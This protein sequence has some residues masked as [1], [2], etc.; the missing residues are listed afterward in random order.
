MDLERRAQSSSEFPLN[1]YRFLAVN[2]CK[3]Y[4]PGFARLHDLSRSCVRWEETSIRHHSR[5]RRSPRVQWSNPWQEKIDNLLSFIYDTGCVFSSVSPHN[6][7]FKAASLIVLLPC[8]GFV[9]GKWDHFILPANPNPESWRRV[10]ASYRLASVHWCYNLKMEIIDYDQK[11]MLLYISLF[12]NCRKI[13][14]AV[15]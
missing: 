13:N 12:T 5:K 4:S 10:R 3:E 14:A 9:Q 1:Y 11:R 8:E 15:T 6:L 7:N 2:M